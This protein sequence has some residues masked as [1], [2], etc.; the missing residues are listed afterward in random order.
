MTL[1]I[2]LQ[3][4]LG[5]EQLT[6]MFWNS[7][8]FLTRYLCVGRISSLFFGRCDQFSLWRKQ[9]LR[10]ITYS[11]K[12]EIPALLRWFLIQGHPSAIEFLFSFLSAYIAVYWQLC[13][14]V[15]LIVPL[16]ARE[17]GFCQAFPGA[18][19]R[20]SGHILISGLFL[21]ISPSHGSPSVNI[22]DLTGRVPTTSVTGQP[23]PFCWPAMPLLYTSD[24]TL[25]DLARRSIQSSLSG[26]HMIFNTTICEDVYTAD[27]LYGICRSR[28][29]RERI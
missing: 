9:A 10:H 14:S 7:P 29:R 11:K 21:L 2:L 20:G 18:G 16:F 25:L 24:I 15:Q 4:W 6:L 19:S 23:T 8:T 27:L 22:L 3:L 17:E 1:T 28:E 12:W 5:E 26:H 13:Q